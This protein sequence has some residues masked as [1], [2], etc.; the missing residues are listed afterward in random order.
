MYITIPHLTKV[1]N[2]RVVCSNL[3]VYKKKIAGENGYATIVNG[4]LGLKLF[5]L[6][7]DD[8]LLS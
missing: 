8:L 2:I 6:S 5:Q 7:N 4:L 3:V 1:N